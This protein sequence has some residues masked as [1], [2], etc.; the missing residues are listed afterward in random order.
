MASPADAPA[1]GGGEVK[2]VELMGCSILF[3]PGKQP[4]PSQL[5]ACTLSRRAPPHSK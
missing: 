5:G 3:P 2:K 1:C 4:F